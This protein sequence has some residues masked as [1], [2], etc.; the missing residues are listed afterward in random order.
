MNDG[1]YEVNLVAL[2]VS[3]SSVKAG[4]MAAGGAGL[5]M[6]MGGSVLMPFI[7]MAAFPLLQRKFL[8]E[9]LAEAKEQIIPLMQEEL[10]NSMMHV[11]NALYKYIDERCAILVENSDSAY[12]FI[13]D[14]AKKEFDTEL[15]EKQNKVQSLNNSIMTYTNMLETI[16]DILN[17]VQEV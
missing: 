5:L 15:R 14:N 17:R 1:R 13:L 8:Q 10:A 11:K 4:A 7:S 2:D 9:K 12:S 3:N 6:L 16:R